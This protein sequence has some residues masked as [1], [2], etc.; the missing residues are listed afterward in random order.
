[1]LFSQVRAPEG[2]REQA[3]GNAPLRRLAERPHEGRARRVRRKDV[4]LEGHARVR[5]PD[6]FK[7]GGKAFLPVKQR[8][9]DLAGPKRGPRSLV[10]R[11]LE[12]VRPR[13]R[14]RSSAC[15]R[16]GRLTTGH[17]EQS[18][19]YQARHGRLHA[20]PLPGPCGL[21]RQEPKFVRYPA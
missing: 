15:P 16:R 5:A 19:E 17:N 12:S 6:G 18:R 2:V 10:H 8:L 9:D 11:I 7:H 21:I 1:M 14:Q 20:F 4:G 3:N 13:L